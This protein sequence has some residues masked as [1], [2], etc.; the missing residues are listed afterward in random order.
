M[1]TCFKEGSHSGRRKTDLVIYRAKTT[2][3]S[4]KS[5]RTLGPKLWNSLP[6]DVKDLIFFLQN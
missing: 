2:R 1:H 5:R 6:E 4:E 3:F